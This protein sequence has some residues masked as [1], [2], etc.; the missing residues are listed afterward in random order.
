MRAPGRVSGNTNS[1][2]CLL[3]ADLQLGPE[4]LTRW[5]VSHIL[6]AVL[7]NACSSDKYNK[8]RLIRIARNNPRLHQAQYHKFNI[9]RSQHSAENII[10]FEAATRP[11]EANGS[12]CQRKKNSITTHRRLTSVL[13]LPNE[14]ECAVTFS[15][16]LWPW[17]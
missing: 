4:V 9:I 16:P 15:S 12:L 17:T 3:N 7:L 13:G 14:R 11:R 10:Q 2:Y 5:L 8:Q 1:L 6:T